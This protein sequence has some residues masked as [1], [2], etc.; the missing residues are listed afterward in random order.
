MIYLRCL[1]NPDVS[2]HH[3][4]MY[5]LRSFTPIRFQGR[6]P[7]RHGD[8]YRAD[9][10]SRA[11]MAQQDLMSTSHLASL[12]SPDVTRAGGLYQHIG[13]RQAVEHPHQGIASSD[14]LRSHKENAHCGRPLTQA[15]HQRARF[16]VRYIPAEVAAID[17]C[18]PQ[19][20]YL[21]FDQLQLLDRHSDALR[22]YPSELSP[23]LRLT[24]TI[25]NGSFQ[26][27]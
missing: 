22:T 26:S 4:V 17:S 8:H 24:V 9:R 5:L 18:L 10:A 13:L 21:F 20:E 14:L 23:L 6:L 25:I 19:V 2:L 1:Q 12:Q 11:S 7:I 15:L 3:S 27:S 16:F